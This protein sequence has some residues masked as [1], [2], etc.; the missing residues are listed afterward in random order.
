MQ[1]FAQVMPNN[2]LDKYFLAS[3]VESSHDSI[4]TINLDMQITSW[5]QGAEVLYGYPAAEAIGKQLTELTLP[6][7]FQQLLIKIEKIKAS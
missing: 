2:N 5:N 6:K 1:A 7:D 4:I 3:I